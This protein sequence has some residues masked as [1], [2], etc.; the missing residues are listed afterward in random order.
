[1]HHSSAILIWSPVPFF[2]SRCDAPVSSLKSLNEQTSRLCQ[3]SGSFTVAER[4]EG[5]GA[6]QHPSHA[7]Y[8]LNPLGCKQLAAGF[9]EE[10]ANRKRADE[11]PSGE[12][13]KNFRPKTVG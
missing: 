11:M 13:V 3:H 9:S 6:V 7:R 2:M 10:F 1:M 4:H 8:Q 12:K 5:A